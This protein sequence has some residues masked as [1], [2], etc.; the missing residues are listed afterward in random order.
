MPWCSSAAIFN[1][2]FT[3]SVMQ[4]LIIVL[5]I[6]SLEI[7]WRI[8]I[9]IPKN[10]STSM[11]IF[12]QNCGVPCWVNIDFYLVLSEMGC[13]L[14]ISTNSF[15]IVQGPRRGF[16]HVGWYLTRLH[17][18]RLAYFFSWNACTSTGFW[19]NWVG[20]AEPVVDSEMPHSRSTGS[21]C[22]CR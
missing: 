20:L 17:G 15:L 11:Y 9:H 22:T 13:S 2:N 3:P 5:A 14:I 18:Y 7:L 6:P 10:Q 12:H 21:W 16:Y 19:M 1:V 8:N 4:L